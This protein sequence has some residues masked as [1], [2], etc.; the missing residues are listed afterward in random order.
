[1]LPKPQNPSETKINIQSDFRRN[2]TKKNMLRVKSN[3]KL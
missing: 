3:R 1:L 2:L